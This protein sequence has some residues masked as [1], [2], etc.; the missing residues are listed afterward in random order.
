M[1]YFNIPNG[2]TAVEALGQVNG[3]DYGETTIY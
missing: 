1:P 2:P 3:H